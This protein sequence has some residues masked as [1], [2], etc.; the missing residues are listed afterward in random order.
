MKKLFSFTLFVALLA[1]ITFTACRKDAKL[2]DYLE[3]LAASQ[4]VAAAQTIAEEDEEEVTNILEEFGFRGC[5]TRTLS[6]PKGTFPQTITIDYG[7]GCADKKGRNR[8]GKIIVTLSD[9]LRKTGSIRT[10]TFENCTIDSVKVEGTRVVT[11]LGNRTFSRKITNHK[12][13]FPNGKV[14]TF[15]SDE[16]MTITAGFLTPLDR[17]DDVWS[18]TGTRSGVNRNG[19][20]Y[21][22]NVTTPLIK[23]GDCR[24]IVSGK[25]DI[26]VNTATRMLDYGNGNCD[27]KGTLTLPDGTTKE[28]PLRKWW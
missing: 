10:V 22:A 13:T 25:L 18:I 6:A 14:A 16:T 23:R 24:W 20:A 5:P 27:E 7:T 26:I 8:T 11:N 12:L 19:K 1:T 4:D 21:T 2:L 9:S 17:T 3:N 28:V 15:N